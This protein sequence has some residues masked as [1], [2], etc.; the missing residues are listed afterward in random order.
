MKILAVDPASKFGWAIS[1][2]EFGEWDLRTRKDESMGMKIIRLRSKLQEIYDIYKFDIL[3]Y[4]RPAGRY[5]NPIIHQS[6][7]IGKLEEFC[8][9]RGIQYR[10]YSATEIKKYATGKGNANKKMM[11]KKAIELYGVE[12]PTDNEA[13]AL[14]L[15]HIAMEEYDSVKPLMK[16]TK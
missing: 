11:I 16:R 8:E 4:E 6:K 15:L 7:L 2:T 1:K 12:N 5:T 14:H 9:D 10:G 13:D 3:V